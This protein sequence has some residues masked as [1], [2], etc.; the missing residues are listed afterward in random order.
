[1]APAGIEVTEFRRAD[2]RDAAR[3]LAA[4]F[5]DDPIWTAIGPRS[6]AH[7]ARSNVVAVWG[8]L[9]GSLRGPTRMRAARETATGRIAGVTIAFA[10]GDWPL[11]ERSVAWEIPWLF[12]A[13]P[14]TVRRGMG[15]DRVLRGAHVR[16]PHN[17]LWFIGVDPEFQGRGVGRALMA[18]LHEWSDPT[19]LPIFLETGTRENVAF[20]SSLGYEEGRELRL[21]TGVPTWHM[22][23]PGTDAAVAR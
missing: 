19:G 17:Y 14:A 4:A 3:A 6:R 16:H 20:Y 12:A 7:R 22:E 21:R 15:D 18:D 2:V 11:P 1:M 8:I 9:Q 23:R 10:D 5:L 13:G